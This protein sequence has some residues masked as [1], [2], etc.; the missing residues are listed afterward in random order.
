MGRKLRRRRVFEAAAVTPDGGS[1]SAQYYD[2]AFRHRLDL[3]SMRL[4]QRRFAYA[5]AVLLRETFSTY[6]PL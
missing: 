3:S 4:S 5:R 6:M 1:G 2:T